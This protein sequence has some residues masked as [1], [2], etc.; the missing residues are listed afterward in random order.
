MARALS[1]D[2]ASEGLVGRGGGWV[3]ISIT[4]TLAPG[5]QILRDQSLS[6]D[7][8]GAKSALCVGETCIWITPLCLLSGRREASREEDPN[9][10]DS[11]MTLVYPAL[12][13][14]KILPFSS[15][16]CWFAIHTK[17][18]SKSLLSACCVPHWSSGGD[19]REVGVLTSWHIR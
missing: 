16:R 18:C 1:N 7:E 9:V 11:R 10:P 8:S 19:I 13:F 4:A 17:S 5:S 14:K 15:W 3:F 6:Q 2:S 12:V